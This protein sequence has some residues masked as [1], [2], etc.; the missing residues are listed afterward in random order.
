MIVKLTPD[1]GYL[2]ITSEILDQ[3]F[4]IIRAQFKGDSQLLLRQ[5]DRGGGDCLH[6]PLVN[7]RPLNVYWLSPSP[8]PIFLHGFK[9]GFRRKSSIFL[10]RC[11]LNDSEQHFTFKYVLKQQFP[12][13][14][15]SRTSKQKKIKLVYPLMSVG[16]LFH[17]KSWWYYWTGVSLEIFQVPLWVRVKVGNCCSKVLKDAQIMF[18]LSLKLFSVKT[19]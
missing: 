4:W 1:H 12:T 7:K 3:N 13:F 19:M 10:N 6:A 15:C 11:L 17:W 8:F 5:G 14:F 9:L 2:S 16:E 18:M